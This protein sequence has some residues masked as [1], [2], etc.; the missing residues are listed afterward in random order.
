MHDDY[1]SDSGKGTFFNNRSVSEC[2]SN[3]FYLIAYL[4]LVI[5]TLKT[6]VQLIDLEDLAKTRVYQLQFYYLRFFSCN[7]FTHLVI[8]GILLYRCQYLGIPVSVHLLQISLWTYVPR[9]HVEPGASAV[10]KSPY[11]HS[12][13]LSSWPEDK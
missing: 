13:Q 2:V 10:R 1:Q 7:T 3:S 9:S 6:K 8:K 11:S 4:S 5:V 12:Q